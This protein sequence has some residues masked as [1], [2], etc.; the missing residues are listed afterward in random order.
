[1]KEDRILKIYGCLHL[2]L[3]TAGI[4]LILLDVGG[5][6][7]IQSAG[8]LLFLFFPLLV[9]REVSV[10]GKKIWGYLGAAVLS[11]S[12][13]WL[14]G[15]NLGESTC[16][17]LGVCF[18][19]LLFFYERVS[20]KREAFFRPSYGCLVAFILEYIF[21]LAYG[22]DR[23]SSVFLIL[24]GCYWLLTL[25]SKNREGFLEYCED[26]ENLY[27]F[28]KQRIAYGN[29]LMLVF[30]T[31]LTVGCMLHLPCL[32]IDRGVLA[33]LELLRKLLAMLLSGN[34]ETGD[35]ES[36]FPEEMGFQPM[37]LEPGQE[38]SPLLTAFWEILKKICTAA[39]G[40]AAIAGCCIFL[41]WL[42]K[43]YNSQSTENGDILENLDKSEKEEKETLARKKRFR[44]SVFSRRT[45]NARIRKYYIQKISR[46]GKPS[47]TYTPWELEEQAGLAEGNKREEFHKL[48]E[49]ARYGNVP[50]TQE[51]A[52]RMKELGRVDFSRKIV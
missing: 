42:Y 30:L 21:S 29:R 46:E 50:C 41:Y 17:L 3:F 11:G 20:G 26:Y 9:L 27:R 40:A 4:L 47:E 36:L 18:F 33:V 12:I 23:L 15:R 28:P 32:G 49:Q 38:T 1:M 8:K 39:A 2:W 5:L 45:P 7:D 43:K 48:Y 14:L 31:V 37:T 22:L 24:T 44:K 25:W 10:R 13:F 19:I 51:E 16:F 34:R 52:R 35:P 6:L